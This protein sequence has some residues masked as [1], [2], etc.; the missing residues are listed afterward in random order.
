VTI[1]ISKNILH[2]G[3][4]K[5]VANFACLNDGICTRYSLRYSAGLRAGLSGVRVPVGTVDSSPYHRV[6]TGSGA[7]SDSC[8]VGTRGSLPGR[9]GRE[10]DS[11]PASS[12]KVKE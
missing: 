10:A 12:A 6:R 7:L 2:H 5:C 8:T 1:S 11:L 9:P 4:S 3:V